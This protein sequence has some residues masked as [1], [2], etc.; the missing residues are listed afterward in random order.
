MNLF[1]ILLLS[2]SSLSSLAQ[3]LLVTDDFEGNGTIDTWA[4]D[5]CEINTLLPNPFPEAQNTSPTVLEYHDVGGQYAN[6]RFDVARNFELITHHTFSFKIYIPSDGLTGNKPNQ[7]SLK[8]QNGAL[9]EPWTTQSEII[10][11]VTLNEW[12]LVTFNF[13]SDNYIN[14]N[15]GSPPP[16]Q[17]FDFNRVLIQVNGENNNSE[18]LAYI[19][20]FQYDGV[21]PE[22]PE[23]NDLVWSDE[24]EENGALD[25]S[26]WFHQTQLPSGGSWFNGEIQHYTNR[27]DNSIVEDGVLRLIAKKETY[28]DQGYTKD[29]TSA[30]LN[31]KFA[32]QYGR[33]DVRAKLPTGIGTWPAI[34]M[35]GKNIDE[36][37]AWWEKQGF[38]TTPWPDCGEI[39]IMEHWGDNQNFVQSA[40]HTPSSFGST[41]NLGGQMVPT[42]STEFHVYSLTWTEEKLI[43]S[44]DD[45]VHFIYNPQEKNAETWPFDAE[46]YLILNTAIL[47]NIDPN[48]SESALEVDYVRVYQNVPVS[49]SQ[50]IRQTD[51]L[52]HYPN[53]VKDALSIYLE[54]DVQQ[55]VEC[56]IFNTLGVLVR[57]EVAE[58][59]DRMIQLDG[60]RNLPAGSY[61][62]AFSVGN[63]TYSVQFIK[64]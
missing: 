57:K 40:T 37:G 14:L 45:M 10:Q 8:L 62:A 42:A 35:L 52:L 18:V 20:D 50:K 51:L 26:N 38:G 46:Q 56:Q 16:T 11:P 21:I 27:T 5:N 3:P 43:F 25:T 48:F 9:P 63:K 58:L 24:F 23:F 54:E 29:Y 39:D 61:F 44:V 49:T 7:V 41:V 17:R 36:D 64:N 30:R 59:N 6:V 19:D 4:G 1:L 60:L 34:W 22:L 31:S 33:V 15:A 12:Q 55:K 28:T 32:F 2:L 53:P 13:E 47:P